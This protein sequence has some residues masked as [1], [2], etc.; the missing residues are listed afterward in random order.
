MGSIFISYRRQDTEGQAGR[1]YGDL[2]AAFGRESVFMDVAGIEPGRD[3]RKAI[4]RSLSSC[5]AFLA[6]IGK[7]WLNLKDA[8]GRRRLDDPADYVRVET[9]MALK[10]DIPLIPVLVQGVRTPDAEQLPDDLKDLAYRNAVELSHPRWDSDVQLLIESLR[11]YVS[12]PSAPPQRQGMGIKLLAVA[13]VV[14]FVSVLLAINLFSSRKTMVPEL[15][16][17]KLANATGVLRAQKLALGKTEPA[18]EAGGMAEGSIVT[19]SPAAGERVPIGS[20][21]DVTIAPPAKSDVGEVIQPKTGLEKRALTPD[22]QAANAKV[23]Q[24]KEDVRSA[25]P[26]AEDPV[27]RITRELQ[28]VAVSKPLDQK[29]AAG[30]PRYLFGKHRFHFDLSVRIPDQALSAVTG[31]HYDFVYTPNPLSMDGGDPPGFATAYEGWGC[32]QTV[33]VTVYLNA[34]ATYSAAN[35]PANSRPTVKKTFDMCTVLNR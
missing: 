13:A 7:D 23:P 26:P 14:V 24:R 21:I 28:L 34:S 4:D 6:M 3:F 15:R 25:P 17:M 27:A 16:G 29:D 5:G 22:P 30:N 19:Q 1:L 35:A 10:R 2:V 20:L 11:P 33:V 18:D 12:K 32:Y 8:S 31:V 9:A